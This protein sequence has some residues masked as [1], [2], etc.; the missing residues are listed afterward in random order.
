MAKFVDTG[1][2]MSTSGEVDPSQVNFEL[3]LLFLFNRFTYIASVTS[4]DF[5]CFGL[6][7]SFALVSSNYSS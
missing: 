1:R 6:T 3:L 4:V 2:T 5:R 7:C